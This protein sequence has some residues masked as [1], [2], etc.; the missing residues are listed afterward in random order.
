MDE[1]KKRI[2]GETIIRAMKLMA[3]RSNGLGAGYAGYGIYPKYEDAY[4]FHIMFENEE[5]KKKTENYLNKCFD[6][7]DEGGIPTKET[8]DITNPPILWRY[9]LQPM[10]KQADEKEFVKKTAMEIN[11]KMG[12]AFVVSS[13]K[14]MGVFKGVGFPEDIAKFYRIADYKAHTWLAHARFP[15]NTPGWWGGAHPFNILDWSVVHNGEISSYGINKRYLEAFNYKC[16]LSTDTE[17]IAYIIDLLA[18]KHKFPLKYVAKVLTP[19]FWTQIGRMPKKEKEFY[20]AIRLTYG[21]ALLNGPFSIIVGFEG[22]MMGLNDRIKLRPLVAGREKS[23]VYLSSEECSIKEIAPHAD[24]WH[25]K[26]GEPTIF[27]LK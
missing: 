6:I 20:N 18:R 10:T 14:N 13:G 9:F 21:G 25:P 1:K 16:T 11:G 5:I 7:V 3:F 27:T 24:T 22:G 26:A 8:L 15:T 2:E 23:R 4:A 12:G 17:V 19:P